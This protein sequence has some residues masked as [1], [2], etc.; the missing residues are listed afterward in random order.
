M[1][2]KNRRE[3]SPDSMKYP[4]AHWMEEMVSTCLSLSI[5]LRVLKTAKNFAVLPVA[6]IRCVTADV[7][8]ES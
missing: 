7:G 2:V 8:F 4:S 5:P 1:T 3:Q 6:G